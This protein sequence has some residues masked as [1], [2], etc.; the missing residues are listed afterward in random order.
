M[1]R[2]TSRWTTSGSLGK[3]GG[4]SPD[5]GLE[6][7]QLDHKDQR[8][9]LRTQLVQLLADQANQVKPPSL[10]GAALKSTPRWREHSSKKSTSNI[11]VRS[12]M[13]FSLTTFNV[14]S[15]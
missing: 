14:H 8:N 10:V 13:R 5:Q 6:Q 12:K 3:R 9:Q 2:K 15:T 4:Q 11:D 7:L 1:K